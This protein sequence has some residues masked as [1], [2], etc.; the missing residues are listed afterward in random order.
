MSVR[1]ALEWYGT[2][3]EAIH[4][5]LLNKRISDLTEAELTPIM[6]SITVLHLDAGKRAR[7]AIQE[8]IELADARRVASRLYQALIGLN[9]HHRDDHHG[10]VDLVLDEDLAE[11]MLA[12]RRMCRGALKAVQGP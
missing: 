12:Y 8:S 3:A 10:G 7:D 9:Q 1:D 4:R 5:A 2:E 11:A 6:A